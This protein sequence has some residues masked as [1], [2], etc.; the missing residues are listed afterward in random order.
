[1]EEC[2]TWKH[3]PRDLQFPFRALW[4]A[5]VAGRPAPCVHSRPPLASSVRDEAPPDESGPR[6]AREAGQ[7]R[8]SNT[9]GRCRHAAGGIMYVW[10]ESGRG[11]ICGCARDPVPLPFTLRRSAPVFALLRV[12]R[13]ETRRLRGAPGSARWTRADGCTCGW[14]VDGIAV[15]SRFVSFRAPGH[16]TP[17]FAKAI[18]QATCSPSILLASLPPTTYD[19]AR[20]PHSL[21]R[22]CQEFAKRDSAHV[23]STTLA[24]L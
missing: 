22:P 4:R 11:R 6:I 24:S 5:S 15:A 17:D 19:I 20:H 13:D 9:W 12:R 2:P 1:M 18:S 23:P 10:L 14:F 7:H 3:T 8:L 21:S 16:A